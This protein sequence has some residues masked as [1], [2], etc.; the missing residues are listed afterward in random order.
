MDIN[1]INVLLNKRNGNFAQLKKII[2]SMNLIPALS[3]D[4]FDLLA[5][6]IL[7]Q[8]ENNSDY[9][10]VKQI[11]ENELTVTYGL[12]RQEFDSGKITDAFFDWWAKN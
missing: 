4:Q 10:K 3:K 11:V 5:E 12:C 9:D 2:V 1:E 6:K 8:L 7:K